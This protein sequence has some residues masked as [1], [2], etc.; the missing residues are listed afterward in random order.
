MQTTSTAPT[1]EAP[2]AAAMRRRPDG[3]MRT[4]ADDLAPQHLPGMRHRRPASA[5]AGSS[6]R[7]MSRAWSGSIMTSG[8]RR[9]RGSGWSRDRC[10]ASAAAK[11]RRARCRRRLALAFEQPSTSRDR[12][13]VKPVP[14]REQQHLA[15]AGRE[16]AE[17]GLRPPRPR[18]ARRR[19]PSGGTA[20]A[21]RTLTASWRRTLRRALRRTLRATPISHGA[22]C[23][24]TSSSRRHATRNVSATTSST[25]SGSRRHTYR[26]TVSWCCFVEAGEPR[27]ACL[28]GIR[29]ILRRRCAITYS[30]PAR[31]DFAQ[32][33]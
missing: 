25:R 31:G 30:C 21:R 27:L 18:A 4:R 6:R 29:V 3:R 24:G 16:R 7:S 1:R 14:D 13:P 9:T 32:N 8:S 12:R 5:A 22:A 28:V 11:R 26:R 2:R 17:R 33:I 10:A 23:S 20:S 15:V 19:S